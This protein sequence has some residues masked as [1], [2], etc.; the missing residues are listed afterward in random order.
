MKHFGYNR[1]FDILS[2]LIR[3][4]CIFLNYRQSRYLLLSTLIIYLFIVLVKSSSRRWHCNRDNGHVQVT[5][6]VAFFS[7]ERKGK[8]KRTT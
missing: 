6:W 7:A 4:I 1:N 2:H 3:N 5:K 8:V